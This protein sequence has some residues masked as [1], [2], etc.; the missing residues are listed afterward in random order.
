M[1]TIKKWYL[2][3]YPTDDLGQEIKETIT[4][5][6]VLNALQNQKDIYSLIDVHDSLIRERI[7]EKLAEI[8]KKSYNEIYS[9]WLSETT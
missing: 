9:L 6:D 5:N 8:E 2:K 7:F 3:T 1:T 4:F